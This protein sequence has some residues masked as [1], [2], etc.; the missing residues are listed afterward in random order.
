MK[1]FININAINVRCRI[2]KNGCVLLVILELTSLDQ[3]DGDF[4]DVLNTILPF[5][6]HIPGMRY[7][8]AGTKLYKRLN[9]DGT[10]KPGNEPIDRVDEAAMR[11]D[12]QYELYKDRRHRLHADKVMIREL[13]NIPKPT[14]RERAERAVVVPI[15]FIKRAIGACIDKVCDAKKSLMEKLFGERL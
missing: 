10:P 9:S 11:H 5:E 12:I 1:R 7:C 6:K 2:I 13:L 15:L 3:T 4:I 14:W 8:G